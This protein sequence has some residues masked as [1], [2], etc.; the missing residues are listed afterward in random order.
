M[1]TKRFTFLYSE[2][3]EG[4]LILLAESLHRSRGDTIRLL[5]REAVISREMPDAIAAHT[6]EKQSNS[7]EV[8]NG[9]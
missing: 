7:A 8:K 4:E 2:K 6:N 1:L 5:I 3:E 9:D